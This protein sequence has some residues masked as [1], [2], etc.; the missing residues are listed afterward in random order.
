MKQE[1]LNFIRENNLS[2][3]NSLKTQLKPQNPI[4][5]TA[6]GKKVHNKTISKISENFIFKD[7]SNIFNF[8][9]FTN[10]VEEVKKRQE[11]F[12]GLSKYSVLD[13]SSLENLK[14]PKNIWKPEY[15]VVVVTENSETF[16][17]L[18][19]M[20]CPVQLIISETDVSLLESRDLVQIIDC[21]EYGILLESLPQ[22]IFYKNIEDVYLERHL[23][24]F[25][26]WAEN[27]KILKEKNSI[28]SIDEISNKLFSLLPLIDN[29][30]KEVLDHDKIEDKIYLANEKINEKLK[31][32][33]LSGT[34]IVEIL[35]R[36][37]LPDSVK[38]IVQ[39]IIDEEKI[40]R[41]IVDI[42]IPLKLNEEEFERILDNELKNEYSNSAEKIKE[43]SIELK[44]IPELLN[45]LE[46]LILFFDFISGA[47]K[48]IGEKEKFPSFTEEFNFK[49]ET[50]ILIDSPKPISFELDSENKCSI[51]TGANSGGKTTLIEHVIQ[52][53]SESQI[54]FAMK[55]DMKIPLFEEVYYFAKNKGSLNK[56]AF[57]N[58]LNQMNKVRSG[59]KTLILADEIESVTEPGV[60]G[61]IISATAKYFIEK[62]C[63]LI[64]ATHLGFEIQN[65]LPPRA[66]IDGIEAKGLTKDFDLIVDHNPVLGRLANS[67]PELI[68]EKMANTNSSEYFRFIN[69]FLKNKND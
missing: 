61:N 17:K 11:F 6:D 2:P 49:N 30:Q 20:N 24:L 65:I 1:I 23:E 22:G 56:G 4:Y 52:L 36:G 27:I 25:S 57:E 66:R 29:E 19:K 32:L 14:K 26:G 50:N 12:M 67:T 44:N 59:N 54:G 41:E 55:N 62:N 64:I 34:S 46:N 9:S 39:K 10:S 16:N 38:E 42:S 60:A 69:N 43:F 63:Y 47:R 8:F 28:K 31:D 5:K 37:N 18:K 48:F 45:E 68:V 53:I 15:D 3:F 21:P 51:L 40:P 33:T 7:T 58:L 35:S 13:N